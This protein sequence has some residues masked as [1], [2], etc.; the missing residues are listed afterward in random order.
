[1]ERPKL[2]KH[3]RE[4]LKDDPARLH[5]KGTWLSA[6]EKFE[7]LMGDEDGYDCVAT[8][9]RAMLRRWDRGA[10]S[11]FVKRVPEGNISPAEE[12][13]WREDERGRVQKSC[14][15]HCL[16]VWRE[17]GAL[18]LCDKCK[19]ARLK[20][21]G[22][23]RHGLR[24]GPVHDGKKHAR[25]LEDK[26]EPSRR[27]EKPEAKLGRMRRDKKQLLANERAKLDLKIR[28]MDG[29]ISKARERCEEID[30]LLKKNQPP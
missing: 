13:A 21:L 22:R 1:M 18:P 7:V 27:E 19:A 29:E 6:A 14:S 26:R 24:K 16:R 2:I 11:R 23:D 4:N 8:F 5:R 30:A 3:L 20:R 28:D 9:S 25:L 12:H 17:I 15:R 10:S